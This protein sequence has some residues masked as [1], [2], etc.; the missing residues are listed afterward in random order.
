MFRGVFCSA[1]V[2]GRFWRPKMS[3]LARILGLLVA[4]LGFH[5]EG[6]E[7]RIEHWGII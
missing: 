2:P 6:R 1:G 3:F 5:V 7:F 4:D